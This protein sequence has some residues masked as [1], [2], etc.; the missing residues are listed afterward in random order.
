MGIVCS[1]CQQIW[2]AIALRTGCC[3][4]CDC[5]TTRIAIVFQNSEEARRQAGRQGFSGSFESADAVADCSVS[6]RGGI[7]ASLAQ[8]I[9]IVPQDTSS[10]IAEA[11]VSHQPVVNFITDL[12]DDTIRRSSRTRDTKVAYSE[13]WSDAEHSRWAPGHDHSWLAMYTPPPLPGQVASVE[14]HA[15]HELRRK[16]QWA[17]QGFLRVDHPRQ[18]I[19]LFTPNEWQVLSTR[20]ET[21]RAQDDEA[22]RGTSWDELAKALDVLFPSAPVSPQVPPVPQEE[23]SPPHTA[24]CPGGSVERPLD[25]AKARAAAAV[26]VL[27]RTS[28]AALSTLMPVIS[29]GLLGASDAPSDGRRESAIALQTDGGS[30]STR[31]AASDVGEVIDLLEQR[32]Q[33]N[34]RLLCS[35]YWALEV[36]RQ[37]LLDCQAVRGTTQ[38]DR[39]GKS[40][41]AESARRS[42]GDR[43]SAG[44][45]VN[46]LMGTVLRAAESTPLARQVQ[47]VKALGTL[48]EHER[49]RSKGKATLRDMVLLGGCGVAAAF[50]GSPPDPVASPP[51]PAPPPP[52]ASLLCGS[53][54]PPSC[55]SVDAPPCG[56]AP[57]Q[58]PCRSQSGRSAAS[59]ELYGPL[60]VRRAM[61]DMIS[62]PEAWHHGATVP[63]WPDEVLYGIDPG[64]VRTHK[65]AKAPLNCEFNTVSGVQRGL[66]YKDGEDLRRDQLVMAI[67]SVVNSMWKK[68]GL[69]LRL[70]PYSVVPVSTGSGLI[71]LVRD[72]TALSDLIDG[73]RLK[74]HLNTDAKRD[75]WIRSNAGWAV[76]SWALGLGDRHLDNMLVT[77]DGCLVHIDFGYILGKDPKIGAPKIKIRDEMMDAIGGTKSPLFRQLVDLAV[78]G[79]MLLR[80]HWGLP[81]AMLRL[82]ADMQAVDHDSR[83]VVWSLTGDK[84]RAEVEKR[85]VALDERMKYGR[86]SEDAGKV[87]AWFADY[88]AA[89]VGGVWYTMLDSGH[90][91]A[92][93]F[94]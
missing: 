53:P 37:G 12:V 66:I 1:S 75:N 77:D 83:K 24:R 2:D 20:E 76:L 92:T 64:S 30:Q 38:G 84:S 45:H 47:L 32:V 57:L 42:S 55:I 43:S 73:D 15:P 89:S 86:Y 54:E 28:D 40:D 90:N 91:L 19:D 82:A 65:T 59:S 49:E 48:R 44:E 26:E 11:Q 69:D 29:V 68:A 70:N 22:R 81:R 31:C 39:D 14:H 67:V 35:T 50:D 16:L 52:R 60:W 4:C 21:K 27:K 13:L 3:S 6:M 71:E 79:F 93:R 18:R 61:E 80:E 87:R 9:V 8:V 63:M 85:I 10:R 23:A 46:R 17:M 88:L 78:Q 62:R 36:V 74:R 34:W 41:G 72:V 51:Q 25:S 5:K 33:G 94:R 58:S 7:G 56:A